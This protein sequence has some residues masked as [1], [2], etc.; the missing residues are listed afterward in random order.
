M[1]I[2]FHNVLYRVYA[3]FAGKNMQ[4]TEKYSGI[5]CIKLYRI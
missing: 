1:G 2:I 5:E 4:N 3:D